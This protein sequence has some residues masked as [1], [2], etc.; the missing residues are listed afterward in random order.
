MEDNKYTYWVFT[1][2]PVKDTVLPD[3]QAMVKAMSILTEKYVFQLEKA[4]SLHYQG[5]CKTV[6]RK[7][8]LTFLNDISKEL[9][10][11]K[12]MITVDPMQG[13]W[14]QA[15]AYCTKS[16]T[17][18]SQPFTNEII[19]QGKD[20]DFLNDET[21]RYPWQQSIIDLLFDKT[22]SSIKPAD[23]RSIVWIEDPQGGNGKSKFVKW[24]CYNNT[25]VAKIS[26]GTSTQL[27]SAIISAGQQKVYFIDVPRTLGSDDSMA[28]LMSALEDLKNGF[29]VSSM[30]GKSQQLVLEPPHIICFSNISC[31]EQ[32]M[33]LDR[34][35]KYV[36]RSSDKTLFRLK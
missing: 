16:E 2:S 26:F 12:E 4:T 22:T 21:K 30:Y 28:S 3:E 7:R 14:E 20:I 19:Y 9:G 27:R 15:K 17:A 24:C 34:W 8:K 5:C 32:F 1:I 18:V 11:R 6:I 23:D 10:I 33:S 13:T 25:N 36:I 29:V 31:P 35:E